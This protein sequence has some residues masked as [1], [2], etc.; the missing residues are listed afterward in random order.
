[1]DTGELKNAISSYCSIFNDNNLVTDK[2][3]YIIIENFTYACDKYYKNNN[4]DVMKQC[5]Q[6]NLIYK[7]I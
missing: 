6:I 2:H 1:M 5:C 7:K 4:V 3:V